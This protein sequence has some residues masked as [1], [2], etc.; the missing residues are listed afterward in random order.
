VAAAEDDAHG[1][2]WWPWWVCTAAAAETGAAESA[3]IV[4]V[5]ERLGCWIVGGEL[6]TRRR[7]GCVVSGMEDIGLDFSCSLYIPLASPL[8]SVSS[9]IGNPEI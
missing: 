5:R 3:I 7:S 4:V 6:L 8:T 2:A 9:E 1:P